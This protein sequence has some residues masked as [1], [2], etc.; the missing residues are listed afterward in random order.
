MGVVVGFDAVAWKAPFDLV[1]PFVAECQSLPI[2][3]LGI[4][5]VAHLLVEA[6]AEDETLEN[7]YGVGP[8][9]SGQEKSSHCHVDL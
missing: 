5:P 4:L 2:V 7:V 1:Q 3:L 9:P 6:S 8:A